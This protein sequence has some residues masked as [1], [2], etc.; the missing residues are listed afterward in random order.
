[1]QAALE[2]VRD[3]AE[4]WFQLSAWEQDRVRE[5]GARGRR[6][7]QSGAV[8]RDVAADGRWQLDLIFQRDRHPRRLSSR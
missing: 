3:A 7:R 4:S 1:M 6:G 5:D 8:K 2:R